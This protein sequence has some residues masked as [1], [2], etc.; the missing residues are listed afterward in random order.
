[1]IIATLTSFT[2]AFAFLFAATDLDAVAAAKLPVLT[3]YTQ[4]LHNDSLAIFFVVW[5]LL[6]CEQYPRKQTQPR[7]KSLPS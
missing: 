5:L 3:L 4:S 1:M 7:E 6:V 2:W